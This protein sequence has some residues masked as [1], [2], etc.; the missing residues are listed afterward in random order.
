MSKWDD[1]DSVKNGLK[2]DLTAFC[3]DAGVEV[4]PK[5]LNKLS[6]GISIIAR[7]SDRF[8]GNKDYE[9]EDQIDE[10]KK[11]T[12]RKVVH[13]LRELKKTLAEDKRSQLDD[14]IKKHSG[15]ESEGDEV[16]RI[17]SLISESNTSFSHGQ[18]REAASAHTDTLVRSEGYEAPDATV[19]AAKHIV[20]GEDK[21]GRKIKWDKFKYALSEQ[22]I[23][24]SLPEEYQKSIQDFPD[25]PFSIAKLEKLAEEG[26]LDPSVID[27]EIKRQ[28]DYLGQ[29]R[30]SVSV[31]EYI[32]GGVKSK[33]EGFEPLVY[34][35]EV[36]E[37]RT[38]HQKSKEC[39]IELINNN[40][41]FKFA[42]YAVE[43]GVNF[44]ELVTQLNIKD[45]LLKEKAAKIK[46]HIQKRKDG[47]IPLLE[48]LQNFIYPILG[49]D[50]PKAELEGDQGSIVRF[51]QT[52]KPKTELRPAPAKSA[53]KAK[54]LTETMRS[55]LEKAESETP[56]VASPPKPKK[57]VSFHGRK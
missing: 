4:N 31:R 35:G 38:K 18:R 17:N 54:E 39:V 1:F 30:E 6:L 11:V 50:I 46:E 20:L 52:F 45:D 25:R 27:A 43:K 24:S 51:N 49:I 34:V 13:D 40:D 32:K 47:K 3:R 16:S 8:E 5:F 23:W 37:Y 10:A 12:H 55:T 28:I 2:D 7:P 26:I 19:E 57:S 48:K 33:E 29:N 41:P 15:I 42:K 44:D 53:L 56:T 21:R 14:L 9:I 36:P 22:K